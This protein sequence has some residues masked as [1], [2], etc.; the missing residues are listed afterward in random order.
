MVKL[1]KLLFQNAESHLPLLNK[2]LPLCPCRDFFLQRCTKVDVLHICPHI[3]IHE[4]VKQ[5]LSQVKQYQAVF[6]SA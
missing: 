6:T 1:S 5:W 4:S 3:A 2:W